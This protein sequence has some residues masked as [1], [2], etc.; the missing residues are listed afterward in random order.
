MLISTCPQLLLE[1]A[2]VEVQEEFSLPAKPEPTEEKLASQFEAIFP[3]HSH[4][5]ISTASADL[6]ISLLYFSSSSIP[7]DILSRLVGSTGNSANL[8]TNLFTGQYLFN[9]ETSRHCDTTFKVSR[10]TNQRTHPRED[11][12]K[13]QPAAGLYRQH[14]YLLSPPLAK[15]KPLLHLK[16]TKARTTTLCSLEDDL[17]PIIYQL[18]VDV[19]R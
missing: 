16:C 8:P 14:H 1:V 5:I 11:W 10:I 17:P 15:L 13:D 9:I 19:F 18:I 6:Q 2:K 3:C 4:Q 7:F 12:K